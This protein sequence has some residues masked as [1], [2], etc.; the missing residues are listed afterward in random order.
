[1]TFN[2]SQYCRIFVM[3]MV[4]LTTVNLQTK[5]EIYRY[6]LGPRFRNRSHHIIM[7]MPIWGTVIF[8][9]H[10][11]N[12]FTVNSYTKFELRSFSHSSDVSVGVKF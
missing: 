4:V 9:H 7:T 5:Y 10:K 1:V 2:T 11:S 12:T 8:N 6:D 3:H